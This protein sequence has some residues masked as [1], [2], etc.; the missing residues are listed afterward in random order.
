MYSAMAMTMTPEI[1]VIVT[2]L[3][4]AALPRAVADRPSTTNTAENPAMKRPVCRAMRGR[5]RLSPSFTSATSSPVI[6]DR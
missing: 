6:T 5:F 4:K 1:R 2:W 3:W